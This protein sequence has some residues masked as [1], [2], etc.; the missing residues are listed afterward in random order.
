MIFPLWVTVSYGWRPYAR[1]GTF[2]G[3]RDRRHHGLAAV[4]A[5]EPFSP[6]IGLLGLLF[7]LLAKLTTTRAGIVTSAWLQRDDVA[8]PT[9]HAGVFICV[10]EQRDGGC[11]CGP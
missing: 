1:R 8:S 2:G 4:A 3:T 6:A 5:R 7:P 10:S 11:L 9:F